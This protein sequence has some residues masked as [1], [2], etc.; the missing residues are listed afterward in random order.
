M[1]MLIELCKNVAHVA[2][3]LAHPEKGINKGFRMYNSH[4]VGSMTLTGSPTG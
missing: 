2:Y 4:G 3:E 1:T